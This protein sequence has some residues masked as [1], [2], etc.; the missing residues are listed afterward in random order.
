[1]LELK[2]CLILIIQENIFYCVS[3]KN[4]FNSHQMCESISQFHLKIFTVKQSTNIKTLLRVFFLSC[5]ISLIFWQ[6]KNEPYKP[7]IFKFKSID[8]SSGIEVKLFLEPGCSWSQ[9]S[10]LIL[11]WN[12]V[13]HCKNVMILR[14][15]AVFWGYMKLQTHY[16]KLIIQYCV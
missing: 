4:N 15:R 5:K 13:Y 6:G 2:Y 3:I 9:V 16:R 8:L 10:V 1:M 12:S 11:H 14:V 7:F